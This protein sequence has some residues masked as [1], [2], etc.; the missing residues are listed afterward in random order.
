[1]EAH[2]TPKEYP[3]HG[4]TMPTSII[5]PV[6]LRIEETYFKVK[7]LIHDRLIIGLPEGDSALLCNYDIVV[8]SKA[9]SIYFIDFFVHEFANNKDIVYTSTKPNMV[10]CSRV[11]IPPSLLDPPHMNTDRIRYNASLESYTPLRTL[12]AYLQNYRI[13]YDSVY[14]GPKLT[15]NNDAQSQINNVRNGISKMFHEQLRPR[16]LNPLQALVVALFSYLCEDCT[17]TFNS[18]CKCYIKSP[19]LDVLSRFC[20]SGKGIPFFVRLTDSK[21]IKNPNYKFISSLIPTIWYI[22][23]DLSLR[24]GC[25]SLTPTYSAFICTKWLK[26]STYSLFGEILGSFKKYKE[27]LPMIFAK[28]DFQVV[29]VNHDNSIVGAHLNGPQGVFVQ[30]EYNAILLKHDLAGGYPSTLTE[31]NDFDGRNMIA[32]LQYLLTP[33]VPIKTPIALSL[34]VSARA[35][36]T[37]GGVIRKPIKF[38]KIRDHFV[39]VK[40]YVEDPDIQGMQNILREQ[41]T[42][43]PPR[44]DNLESKFIEAATTNSAGV[45][46]DKL[47]QIRKE[48]LKELGDTQDAKE[49]AANA[50]VRIF[51]VLR[52]IQ[53][54]CTT[55]DAIL[56]AMDTVG[57]SGIRVQ[58]GRRN[59]LIQMLATIFMFAP[60][61][62]KTM[63]DNIIEHSG[64]AATGKT[65]NDIRDLHQLAYATSHNTWILYA[66]VRG[67]DTA[68][69]G[70]Q[71]QTLTEVLLEYGEKVREFNFN[72]FLNQVNGRSQLIK[73]LVKYYDNDS[74]FIKEE[75]ESMSVLEFFLI[76]DITLIDTIRWVTDGYFMIEVKA[77]NITFPS[78][79][80][81]TSAQHTLLLVLLY[82]YI[83]NYFEA[84]Y[85]DIGL[86]L[87]SSVLGDDQV[88]YSM[89]TSVNADLKKISFEIQA[90]IDEILLK[91]S[92][93][94]DAQVDYCSGEFL[95]QIAHFGC[96]SPLGA[97]LAQ[98]SSETGGSYALSTFDRL[99][100]GCGVADELSA[101]VPRPQHTVA[102]KRM[103]AIVLSYISVFSPSLTRYAGNKYSHS[104]TIIHQR[105]TGTAPKLTQ[106]VKQHHK[107]Y[108]SELT[109]TN[110]GGDTTTL[111]I[112]KGCWYTVPQIGIPHYAMYSG[113]T[114]T[115]R[116]PYNWL[117]FPSPATLKSILFLCSKDKFNLEEMYNNAHTLI[118]RIGLMEYVKTLPTYLKRDMNRDIV[119]IGVELMQSRLLLN[120]YLIPISTHLRLDPIKIDR[121]GYY[122]GYTY[123]PL[124][125]VQLDRFEP[126]PGFTNLQKFGNS[127]LDTKMLTLSRVASHILDTEF[128]FKISDTVAYYNRIGSRLLNA[129]QKKRETSSLT[130]ALYESMKMDNIGQDKIPQKLKDDIVFGDY[131]IETSEISEEAYCAVRT[132]DTG[133]GSCVPPESLQSIYID[134]FGLP[135][136]D[137]TS[138]DAVR[139]NIRSLILIE[140]AADDVIRTLALLY[141]K[142]GEKALN[143]G[144]DAIG[145]NQ[146]L[147]KK[148]TMMF[149]ELGYEVFTFP[150][151]MNPRKNFYYN[152]T[153]SSLQPRLFKFSLTSMSR[154]L[155]Y[156]IY[157]SEVA[158]CPE[159]LCKCLCVKSGMGLIT[160][161]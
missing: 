52:V 101:R 129:A 144:F 20:Q 123:E 62:V 143:H 120:R 25:G 67:M 159:L 85:V 100:N 131:S 33:S 64:I 126:G 115:I 75:Y 53:N 36:N 41:L 60:F 30:E 19:E 46:A 132:Y 76:L 79:S 69:Y 136:M 51:D 130:L 142:H 97:R 152:F 31:M 156:A 158:S 21:S 155:Q 139:E 86:R 73:V 1:M 104:S 128:N 80:Y 78:G 125:R 91:L 54:E 15:K 24:T 66:D 88:C 153:A 72:Y 137:S 133:Y 106:Q 112:L 57:K 4:K 109:W 89:A 37:T 3:Q 48:I 22:L 149:T 83:R 81:K 147:R 108:K 77:S 63:I 102:I 13:D 61:L 59:R 157:I 5:M 42:L 141:R 160:V 93:E 2:F 10:T 122:D 74:K 58:V 148:I 107:I 26:A 23:L 71:Q 146:R 50:G 32:M 29:K 99:K 105:I 145:I 151:A 27:I 12:D 121:Y 39:A 98:F 55:V 111:R 84:K 92:Y 127:F 14:M 47:A 18:T 135:R 7:N 118:S 40:W 95:K 56:R 110:T 150:Y 94:T 103:K 70:P 49:I 117:S 43:H 124:L 17:I 6:M 161:K 154:H 113:V 138:L 116:K 34:D 9:D 90:K 82:M 96:P 65:T 16:D 68:T 134:V 35:T 38:A 11:E 140:G 44:L 8:L 28:T 119:S 114:G 87:F 45:D